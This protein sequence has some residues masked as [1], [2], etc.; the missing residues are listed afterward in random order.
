MMKSKNKGFVL[1]LTLLMMPSLMLLLQMIFC[2]MLY[3][4][5]KGKLRSECIR[6]SLSALN[7]HGSSPESIRQSLQALIQSYPTENS[8]VQVRSFPANEPRNSAEPGPALVFN[9]NS[10]LLIYK[11]K[12]NVNFDCG[13]KTVWKNSTRSS[14]IVLGK[15]W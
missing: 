12:L 14:E 2:T 7:S 8:S 11:L 1:L 15:F 13:A 9:L 10:D 5:F 6:Q 3:T 4:D